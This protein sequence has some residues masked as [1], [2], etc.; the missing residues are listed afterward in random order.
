MDKN[1]VPIKSVANSNEEAIRNIMFLYNI[2]QFDLDCTYSKGAFWKNL[3]GPRIK[4]DLIPTSDDV[5]MANSENLPFESNSMTNIMC[6]LPFVI[7]GKTYKTNAEGSSIIAKRFEGYETYGHLKK[8]YYNTLKEL[9]RV[10]DNDGFVVFKC[11]DSVSGGLNYFTHS[12]VINMANEIG[13]YVRDMIVL[14]AK[15]RLNS[16]GGKWTRQLHS[17]KYHSYF[18]ILQ[19][20]KNK[21]NHNMILPSNDIFI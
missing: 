15:V 1:F 5:I 19:K 12:L 7:V 4:S 10:C 3:K 14:V 9:Y 2:E 18:I 17:R 6:D 11:Q 21:V 8:N 13:F 16:F 20:V